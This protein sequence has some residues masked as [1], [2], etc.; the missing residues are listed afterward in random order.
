MSTTTTIK[1]IQISVASQYG[2]SLSDMSSDKRGRRIAR[3]RQVAMFL[4]SQ[5]TG[6]SLPQIGRQ[7]GNRDHTTVMH[8]LRRID[9]LM[10]EDDEFRHQVDGLRR[11]I[12]KFRDVTPPATIRSLEAAAVWA[13]HE[14]VRSAKTAEY[15]PVQG[16]Y[17]EIVR[18][19]KEQYGEVPF[20]RCDCNDGFEM[21]IL[22]SPDGSWSRLQISGETA[23][24]TEGGLNWCLK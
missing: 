20:C 10:A 24:L 17:A 15:R 9:S 19:L 11:S 2:I 7:F 5:L 16:S 18:L 14:A 12:Q 13:K 6:S 21:E 23:T 22:V 4:S 1:A 3:P 8:A